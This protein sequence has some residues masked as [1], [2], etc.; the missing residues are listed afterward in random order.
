M[1][2]FGMT[3]CFRIQ[4]A[5]P[6]NCK[7]FWI[8]DSR[9]R[10]LHTYFLKVREGDAEGANQFQQAGHFFSE[11]LGSLKLL[12]ASTFCIVLPI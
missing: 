9:S 2:C 3:R 8:L 10:C 1:F 11:T 6:T 4:D 5:W 12:R 7:H